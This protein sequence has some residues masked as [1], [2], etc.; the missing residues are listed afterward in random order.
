MEETVK[1]NMVFWVEFILDSYS[2]QAC[3]GPHVHVVHY[4]RG[5]LISKCPFGVI[6]SDKI[7]TI[8]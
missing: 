7:P 2:D 4:T 6:V 3:A 8:F 5:Q 1:E